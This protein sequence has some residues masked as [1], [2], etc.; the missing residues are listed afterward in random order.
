MVGRSWL[1]QKRRHRR[2]LLSS[3][4]LD[5]PR[6][7]LPLAFGTFDERPNALGEPAQQ[8]VMGSYCWGLASWN[9]DARTNPPRR[10]ADKEEKWS[11][12]HFV[13]YSTNVINHDGSGGLGS[14]F[15]DRYRARRLPTSSG[16]DGRRLG[17]HRTSRRNH[18][19]VIAWTTRR[20]PRRRASFGASGRE[21][22]VRARVI[23]RR[24]GPAR[25]GWSATESHKGLCLVTQ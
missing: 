10:M 20:A 9:G 2:S 23:A 7:A 4:V 12:D 21:A 24:A 13:R 14:L 17:H 3:A 25:A 11:V 18:I 22:F 1:H 15:V 16:W 6:E 8:E 5:A 19:A